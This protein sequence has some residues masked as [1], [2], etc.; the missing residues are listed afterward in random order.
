MAGDARRFRD[1]CLAEGRYEV[2]AARDLDDMR[3]MLADCVMSAG[4]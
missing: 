2:I 1:V 3:A 4:K